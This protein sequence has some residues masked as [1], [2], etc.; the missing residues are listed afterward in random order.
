VSLPSWIEPLYDAETAQGI[1]RWAID[2]LGI[3]SLDLMERAAQGLAGVV[4]QVAPE[5]LVVVCCGAGNNGGDG[6]A[7]ARI[8]RAAWRE[9]RVLQVTDA[10]RLAGDALAQAQRL[11][12]EPA[13]AFTPG[14]LDG[15][16]VIVDAIL[17]TGASGPPREPVAGALAAIAA[18]GAPV[19]AADS[20]SGVDAST[21]A[22]DPA[23]VRAVATAA[24]HSGKPGLWIAPGKRHAGAVSVVGI[25]IPD[26]APGSEARI[27]LLRDVPLLATLPRRATGDTKFTSGR[28][29]VAGGSPGLLGA[30]VLACTAAARAGAGYVSAC[31]PAGQQ[32]A[33][34][35][36]LVE[37]MQLALPEAGGHHTPDGIE[38]LLAELE[39]RGGALVLGPG[40]GAGDGAAAFARG[41]AAR[42]A[43][44]LI[45]D[46]DGL[47]AHAGDLEALAARSAPTVITPHEGELGRLLGVPSAQVAEQRLASARDAASRSGS[48][49]VL[50]GDD[51]LI[52]RPDGF[53]AVSSGATPALATAGTG[54]VLSGVVGALLARGIEPFRAACAAVRLHALAAGAAS[55][56]VGAEGLIA[57][58]VVDELARARTA[59]GRGQG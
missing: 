31:V 26:G 25:G 40:L 55:A 14:G 11:V 23:A 2:D 22:A 42:A 48:I 1:D 6:Y 7:A 41:L 28:V 36:Q 44:P 45:L 47:N 57:R 12:G 58:D 29:L 34:A 16:A 30:V 49:V 39:R 37:V 21:G 52:A 46:A 10:S 3:P 8:L 32:P 5:G 9:V 35:A 19:V 24:F 15:A 54:D 18:S 43:A 13:E 38:P 50:K 56:R 53:V 27:G 51:T 20:P 4:Q 33:L 17:G 59:S